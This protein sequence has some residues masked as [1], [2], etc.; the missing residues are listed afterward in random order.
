MKRYLTYQQL[1]ESAPEEESVV[2][3]PTPKK[4]RWLDIKSDAY[5][6]YDAETYDQAQQLLEAFTIKWQSIEPKA[7]HAFKWGIKRTFSY[8]GFDPELHP[9]IRTTNLIERLFREF[10]AKADEIG[11]FP[12]E[13]SC[14]T[15][16]FLVV[17]REHAKHN[18][19][20]L[21]KT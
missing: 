12:N 9:H 13:A 6:I 16:F 15:L 19:P 3:K 18:R 20:F 17:R 4:Q 14:L 5:A 8:Y 2:D 21:A 10:R 1:P 7:V 11:A